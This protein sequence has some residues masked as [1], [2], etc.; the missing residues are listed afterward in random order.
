M[1]G[2]GAEIRTSDAALS[3]VSV[4]LTTRSQCATPFVLVFV[5]FC[6]FR[7]FLTLPRPL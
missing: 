6:H 1:V 4:N 3:L 7:L 2:I 5:D